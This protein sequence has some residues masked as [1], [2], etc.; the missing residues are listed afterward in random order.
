VL[1]VSHV[2]RAWEATGVGTDSPCVLDKEQDCMWSPRARG[3]R[4]E[5]RGFLVRAEGVSRATYT[6]V[7]AENEGDAGNGEARDTTSRRGCPDTRV[8]LDVRALASPVYQTS[9]RVKNFGSW[10]A[11]TAALPTS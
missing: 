10:S 4:A 5:A 8:Y 7:G 9:E 6:H 11:T 2:K 3:S 1:E